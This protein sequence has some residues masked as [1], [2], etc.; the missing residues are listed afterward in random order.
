MDEN[1]VSLLERQ[2]PFFVDY[3]EQFP[4]LEKQV[5]ADATAAYVAFGLMNMV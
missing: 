4:E 3:V 2:S 5:I 1:M